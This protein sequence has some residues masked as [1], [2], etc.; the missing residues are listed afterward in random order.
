MSNKGL[1]ILAFGALLF[2]KVFRSV[3]A[4]KITL[5]SYEVDSVNV[6]D[7][8]VR[9][10]LYFRIVNPLW[11]GITLKEIS[12][13]LTATSDPN[14][15]PEVIGTVY[16]RYNY[17]IRGNATH[18]VRAAVKVNTKSVIASAIENINS[19]DINNYLLKFDGKLVFGGTREV[20]L[21]IRR[22]MTIKEL[23]GK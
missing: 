11:I 5:A 2:Y 18:T 23:L 21:P 19:G 4:L 14:T 12:G 1:A 8:T 7:G 6:A 22:T 10:A 15:E 16:N 3:Q 9:M 13:E 17:F 20:S